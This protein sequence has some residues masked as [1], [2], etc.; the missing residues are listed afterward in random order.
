MCPL[1]VYVCVSVCVSVCMFVCVCL[2]VCVCVFVCVC[3]CV[4][5]CLFVYVWKFLT[6]GECYKLATTLC[7][8]TCISVLVTIGINCSPPSGVTSNDLFRFF[9]YFENRDIAKEVL[10]E[11]GLKKIRIGIEGEGEGWV[12]NWH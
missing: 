5:A 10:R 3:M 2:Y 7:M 8:N 4:C 6:N 11:K 12:Q 1:H 9:K